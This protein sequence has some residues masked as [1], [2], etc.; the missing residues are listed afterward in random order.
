MSKGKLF[1]ISAPSGSGKTTLAHML[2]ERHPSK[3]EQSIS[4]TTRQKRDEEIHGRHYH[5]VDRD[6]FEQKRSQNAFLEWAELYGNLYG[7]LKSEIKR[8][9][10]SGKHAL[11]VIDTQGA[12]QLMK[13]ADATFI[14]IE[15]PSMQELESR[16]TKR[17]AEKLSERLC[18]AKKELEKA[19]LYD[20]RIC[21]DELESACQE[22]EK[23]ILGD[24]A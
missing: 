4:C 9:T 16:L 23:I 7:T 17:G 21:N 6:E 1:V 5:F 20:Y 18:L 10:D 13:S 24:E 22:L 15:P 2:V 8:I 14:F 11:L 12:E 19:K 3:I